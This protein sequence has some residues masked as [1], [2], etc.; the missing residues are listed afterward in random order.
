MI[1]IFGVLIALVLY[2]GLGLLVTGG[3]VALICWCFS[4]VFSWK[5]AIGIYIVYLV[6]AGLFKSAS[7]K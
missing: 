4:L 7:G 3:L 1:R 6:V 2:L 5:L